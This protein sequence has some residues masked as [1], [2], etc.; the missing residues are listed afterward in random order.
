MCSPSTFLARVCLQGW[1]WQS[2]AA[3]SQCQPGAASLGLAEATDELEPALPFM[4]QMRS[5]VHDKAKLLEQRVT[6]SVG[7]LEAQ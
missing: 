7:E 6:R 1:L 4:G 5:L 3:S 2:Q